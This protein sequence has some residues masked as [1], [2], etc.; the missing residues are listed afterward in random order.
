MQAG[1]GVNLSDSAPRQ[2][3]DD[4]KQDGVKR[5]ERSK[6]KTAI[7]WPRRQGIAPKSNKMSG[8]ERDIQ[9]SASEVFAD[10]EFPA[11]P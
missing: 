1:R 6:A 8:V 4:D 5:A 2:A 11:S 7:I 10:A 3:D 9:I